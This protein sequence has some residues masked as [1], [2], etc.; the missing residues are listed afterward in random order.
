MI[1]NVVGFLCW[2]KPIFIGQNRL[3]WAKQLITIRFG[4]INHRNKNSIA[5]QIELTSK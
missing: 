1:H 4:L 5:H 2:V 3:F